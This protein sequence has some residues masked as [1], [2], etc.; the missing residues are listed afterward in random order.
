MRVSARIWAPVDRSVVPTTPG[1]CGEEVFATLAG[2][3]PIATLLLA[4]S[5]SVLTPSPPAPVS[6]FATIKIVVLGVAELRMLIGGENVAPLCVNPWATELK[7][8]P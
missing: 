6:A 1:P 2:L 3:K 5:S 8:P 4:P 7:C